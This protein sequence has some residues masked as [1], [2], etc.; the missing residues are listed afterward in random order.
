MSPKTVT[1][2]QYLAMSPAEQFAYQ[3]KRFGAMRRLVAEH[4]AQSMPSG[5]HSR[6]HATWVLA[7]DL[8]DAGLDLDY[9]IRKCIEASGADFEQVWVRPPQQQDPWGAQTAART[10]ETSLDALGINVDHRVDS[11]V[12]EQMRIPPSRRGTNGRA[13]D[14]PF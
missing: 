5:V 13:D 4:I 7:E 11:L 10:L 3:C 9:L 6:Q 14:C 2:D 1:T 12:L 8:D